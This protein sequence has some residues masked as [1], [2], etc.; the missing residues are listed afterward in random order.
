[1]SKKKTFK[2]FGQKPES[3]V[4]KLKKN[5]VQ[6]GNEFNK[7][8]EVSQNNLD[9]FWLINGK[10][11]N[12]FALKHNQSGVIFVENYFDDSGK[13]ND[14]SIYFQS[15]STIREELQDMIDCIRD[16]YAQEDEEIDEMTDEE[17]VTLYGDQFIYNLVQICQKTNF[18]NNRIIVPN[19]ESLNP[20][21]WVIS[22]TEIAKRA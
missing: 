20:Y 3:S 22:L 8:Q 9:V 10:E 16:E 15:L 17:V 5:L 14:K 11:L 7:H 4:N 12:D 2:G 6:L 1:M 21:F 18:A 13:L 19:M